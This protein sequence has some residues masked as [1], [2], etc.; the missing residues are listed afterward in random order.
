[1][2]KRPNQKENNITIEHGTDFEL[3]TTILDVPKKIAELERT[4]TSLV[5][6]VGK[7]QES[8]KDMIGLQTSTAIILNDLI[9]SQLDPVQHADLIE[10]LAENRKVLEGYSR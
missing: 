8:M 2:S 3:D 10:W 9:R 6:L 1:M 7:M 4:L 5:A